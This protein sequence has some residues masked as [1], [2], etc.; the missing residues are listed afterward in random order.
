M[1]SINSFISFI[2]CK[3][4]PRLQ[5]DVAKTNVSVSVICIILLSLNLK[6]VVQRCFVQK[7]IFKKT[8]RNSQEKIYAGVS[9]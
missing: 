5:K 7:A 1:P 4:G 8:V 9:L 3:K 6:A 2:L